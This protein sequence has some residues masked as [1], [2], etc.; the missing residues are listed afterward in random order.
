MA[1]SL[2]NGGRG[3]RVAVVI[4]EFSFFMLIQYSLELDAA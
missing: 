1:D 3:G 4:A 2:I